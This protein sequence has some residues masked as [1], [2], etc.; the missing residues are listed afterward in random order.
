[1]KLVVKIVL[2]LKCWMM[3]ASL[4]SFVRWIVRGH[5]QMGE[6]SAIQRR[7]RLECGKIGHDHV[8][9]GEMNE[10]IEMNEM[11]QMSAIRRQSCL[12]CGSSL[13]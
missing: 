4:M 7:S 2:F 1:M 12:G 5:D 8:H 13:F 6:M 9:M 10:M 11:G 3:N